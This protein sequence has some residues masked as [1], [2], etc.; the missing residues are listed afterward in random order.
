MSQ[1]PDEIILD[2]M[3]GLLSIA[4]DDIRLKILYLI[5]D[6]E[7]NVSE[8][9]VAIGASQSLVSHQLKVLRK[10]HLVRTHKEGRKVFYELADEHI[11]KLLEVVHE[12]VVE[13]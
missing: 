9:V 11:V 2:K 12:H 3:E 8:I 6:H 5:S 13:K 4:S 10:A 7:A 1:L